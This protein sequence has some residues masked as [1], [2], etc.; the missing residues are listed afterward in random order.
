MISIPTQELKQDLVSDTP[1]LPFISH[2]AKS[3]IACCPT[4][5]Q[6][7]K[8]DLVPG[9]P[10]LPGRSLLGTREGRGFLPLAAVVFQPG[11]ELKSISGGNGF[12]KGPDEGRLSGALLSVGSLAGFFAT[13]T[14]AGS[15]P[16]A[17]VISLSVLVPLLG[18]KIIAF[19][20]AVVVLGTLLPKLSHSFS[21]PCRGAGRKLS[22]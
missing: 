21:L 15:L 20:G 12:R 4:S 6:E 1:L 16:S 18:S 2:Q 5:L 3:L 8:Q 10:L 17:L 13:L 11:R 9:T 19:E 14:S 7:L 22:Y